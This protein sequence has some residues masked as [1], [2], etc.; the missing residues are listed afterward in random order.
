MR[1][2]QLLILLTVFSF[3]AIAQS[4]SKQKVNFEKT[5]GK[6]HLKIEKEVDGKTTIIDKTYNSLEE[7]KNDPELEGIDLHVFDKNSN[8]MTFFGEEGEEGLHKM[9]V[10]VKV[11]GDSDLTEEEK[12]TFVFKSDGDGTDNLHDFNVWI[13]EDGEKH[14]SKNGEEIDLSGSGTWTDKDGNE[15]NIKNTDGK[16]MIF[17]DEDL[18]EFIS[19]DGKSFEVKFSTDNMED[20][21]HKFMMYSSSDDGDVKHKTITV[22]VLTSFNIHVE[23]VQG[24]EFSKF[25]GINA[26]SLKMN[27]LNY[28]PNP[29]NGKFT[30][31]FKADRR[32]TKI[33]ITSLEGREIYAESLSSFEGTYQNEIDLSGQKQGIYLLQ[34]LQGKKA[35]NKKIVIE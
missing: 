17:S 26:K 21:D 22:D 25:D 24:D 30:L 15:F 8:E 23:D 18:N 10:M 32:P 16:V 4:G 11:N 29:N 19:E 7:M 31:Q 35:I 27:E 20:G 13:D 9:K 12:H 28:Y 6:I 1:K 34:I 14:L 5:D 33:R 3:G 2:I